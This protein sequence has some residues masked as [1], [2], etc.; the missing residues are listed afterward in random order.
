MKRSDNSY[1][2]LLLYVDDM[3]IVRAC[4]E[5]IDKQNKGLSKGISMKDLKDAKPILVMRITRDK[6]NT[7]L[8]LSQEEYVK[9]V[10]SRFNIMDGAKPMSILLVSHFKLSKE[11]SFS[12]EQERPTWPKFLKFLLLKALCMPWYVQD[13]I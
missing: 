2:I 5:E 7:I 10:I 4:K 8:K 11:Q 13:Q 6:V 3:L 1:I 12:T 9:K